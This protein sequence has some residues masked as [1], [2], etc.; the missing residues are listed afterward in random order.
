MA[1]NVRIPE[2][3]IGDNYSSYP[4]FKT[5]LD[6]YSQ[7][8]YQVF[9]VLDSKKISTANK[10][11]PK[12][13][14]PESLEVGYAKLTCTHY[15]QKETRK[16]KLPTGKRPKQ[17]TIKT[18]CSAYIQLSGRW[19]GENACLEII[20]LNLQHNHPLTSERYALHPMKRR[21]NSEEGEA[22]QLL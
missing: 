10:S 12:K 3:K 16:S 8:S 20:G 5:Y 9:V 21:L 11:R 17:S 14:L 7:Q 1:T 18:D 15:G 4:E 6:A 22:V 19:H 13:P 2:P